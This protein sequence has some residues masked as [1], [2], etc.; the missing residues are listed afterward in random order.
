MRRRLELG[1]RR[2]SKSSGSSRFRLIGRRA[3]GAA[4]QPR[5]RVVED[6]LAGAL[7]LAGGGCVRMR[8]LAAV[9]S[10]EPPRSATGLFSPSF[11]PF[12]LGPGCSGMG[13]F[14]WST[15]GVP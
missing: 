9:E 11:L 14:F 13:I 12:S 15:L 8:S 7:A 6:F 10:D 2:R 1:L 4:N 5:L 3:P